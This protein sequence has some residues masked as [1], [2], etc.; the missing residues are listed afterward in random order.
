M[1]KYK[2]DADEKI[3]TVKGFLMKKRPSVMQLQDLELHPYLYNSGLL[4]TKVMVQTH[5]IKDTTKN[6]QRNCKRKQFCSI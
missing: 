1:S 5:L 2:I 3:M 4:F 6:I